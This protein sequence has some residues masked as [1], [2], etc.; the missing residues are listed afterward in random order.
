MKADPAARFPTLRRVTLPEIGLPAEP[1]PELPPAVFATRLE[2][3]RRR[4]L[5]RGLDALVVYGDREHFSNI[6]WLTHYDP[7]FEETLLVIRPTGRPI[8]FVGNE[9]MGYSTVARL[10]V[11]RRL[12]QSLSLLG[13]PREQVRPLAGLLKEAGLAAGARVG[14]A[15]WKYFSA[16]EVPDPE[17]AL[18]LPDFIAAA[19]RAAVLP[20]GRIT[21][22]TALFMDAERGLR[23]ACEVEQLADFEW[24]A[25]CNSQAVLEGV[26][27]IRP[28]MTEHEAFRHMGHNGLANGCHPLVTAG[29]RVRRHGMASPT[30]HTLRLGDPVMITMS[31]QGANTCRFGWLAA[32]AGELAP[33]IRDYSERV[34]APYAAALFAW[35]EAMRIGVTGSELHGAVHG[36]LDGAS[37]T[38]GLNA[39]HLIAT[40]EWVHSLVAAGSQQR[41]GSGMYWQADFFGLVPTAHHG[42]FAEDGLAIA[43]APLRERI[44]HQ[45]PAMWGRIDSRRSFMS[46][47]LGVT[48]ADEVLP[49]SNFPAM[50]V[51]FFR[52]PATTLVRKS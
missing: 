31:Y 33:D 34:A 25:T 43:D 1:R 14:A 27:A 51:P 48:L 45:Y 5:E 29:D 7:R 19:L 11:E 46:D 10:D 17:T 49:F 37:V 3:T 16:A 42:A 22:E 13:Q 8:L 38:V 28:G 20:G 2:R 44:R 6:H 40:D 23:V 9:G 30:S 4:M 24:I 36:I 41:V 52:D 32:S 39:G 18:D 50:V 35:Y 26:R 47:Q 15:G 12:W 21:N